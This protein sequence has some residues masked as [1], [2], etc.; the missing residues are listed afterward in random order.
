MNSQSSKTETKEKEKWRKKDFFQLS[1]TI[2]TFVIAIIAYWQATI[3]N[4]ATNATLRQV[5]AFEKSQAAF[6]DVIRSHINKSEWS[7]NVQF[8]SETE[9]V[10]ANMVTARNIETKSRAELLH[11]DFENDNIVYEANAFKKHPP[12]SNLGEIILRDTIKTIYKQTEIDTT[13][14]WTF[15]HINI[16]YDDGFGKKEIR[17][18]GYRFNI[19][20]K[21]KYKCKHNN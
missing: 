2:I 19:I 4:K 8:T 21:E 1:A 17:N 14:K 3:S 16:T 20:S 15:L 12:L 11:K 6:L 9:I 7:G 18:W 10:N 5:I 13:K